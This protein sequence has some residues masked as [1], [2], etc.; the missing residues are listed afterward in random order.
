[1]SWISRAYGCWLCMDLPEANSTTVH[2]LYCLWAAC[3][4]LS[5]PAVVMR[6]L[7]WVVFIPWA[8]CWRCALAVALHWRDS[9]L[10]ISHARNYPSVFLKYLNAPVA[11]EPP[12]HLRKLCVCVYVCMYVFAALISSWMCSFK[13]YGIWP[14]AYIHTYTHTHTHTTSVNAVTLV[15]GSLRLTPNK[16]DLTS[17]LVLI[18][19]GLIFWQKA[20]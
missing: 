4:C 12:L 9:R 19:F 13:I 1:M 5:W 7:T 6:A 17:R 18:N 10:G 3:I 11:Y 2:D 15:W 8:S 20:A 16:E 14:Q